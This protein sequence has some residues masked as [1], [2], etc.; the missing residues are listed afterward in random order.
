MSNQWIGR[1][2]S[3]IEF[4]PRSPNLTVCD[5]FLWGYLRE[6]VYKNEIN[7]FNEL[8]ERIQTELSKN[9]SKNVRKELRRFSKTV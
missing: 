6:I 3:P 1:G 8:E 5:F 9:T 7:D 4:P 2:S